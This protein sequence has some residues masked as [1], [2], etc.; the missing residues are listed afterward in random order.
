[1]TTIMD[2][3]N[4]SNISTTVSMITTTSR[5]QSMIT[6]LK[7]QLE[8]IKKSHSDLSHKMDKLEDAQKCLLREN[9]DPRLDA[10]NKE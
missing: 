5:D 9:N 6:Q 4:H 10:T 2:T 3:L 7:E 8:M 1:M